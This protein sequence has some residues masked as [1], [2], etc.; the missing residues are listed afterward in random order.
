MTQR[1]GDDISA[2]CT[3]LRSSLRCRRTRSMSRFRGCGRTA[4]RTYFPMAVRIALPAGLG[5][6]QRST[7]CKRGAELLAADRAVL[8]VDSG[9]SAGSR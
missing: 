2:L 9:G 6:R 7:G 5:V 8:I 3:G 1:R 4:F